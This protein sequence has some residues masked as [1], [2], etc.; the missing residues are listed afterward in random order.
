MADGTDTLRRL[1]KAKG[2]R[3]DVVAATLEPPMSW[4]TLHRW[5]TEGIPQ[6]KDENRDSWL[7]Q[8]AERYGVSV[9]DLRNGR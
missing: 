3:Q 4:R 7:A 1:R 2:L 5:E 6:R 9:E 8:L